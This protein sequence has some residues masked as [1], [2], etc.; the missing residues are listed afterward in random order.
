MTRDLS[1]EVCGGTGVEN[2]HIQSTILLLSYFFVFLDSR[3]VVETLRF[4]LETFLRVNSGFWTFIII[5][6]MEI[7]KV[8]AKTTKHFVVSLGTFGPHVFLMNF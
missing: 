1:R 7:T 4:N 2:N 5:P 3:V 8:L 6:S